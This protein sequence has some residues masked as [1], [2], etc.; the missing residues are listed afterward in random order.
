M[1]WSTVGLVALHVFAALSA[2]TSGLLLR[3]SPFLGCMALMLSGML[4][5]A[6]V[7][8]ALRVDEDQDMLMSALS[9]PLLD[10]DEDTLPEAVCPITTEPVTDVKHKTVDPNETPRVITWH[11]RRGRG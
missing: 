7:S 9:A 6:L 10:D 4:V 3:E 1:K 8:R 5:A 11:G 2:L